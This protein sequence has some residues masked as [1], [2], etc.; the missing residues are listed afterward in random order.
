MSDTHEYV[1]Y[2]GFKNAKPYIKCDC[3]NCVA[4]G[5]LDCYVIPVPRVWTF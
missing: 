4:A 1:S 5:I 2:A 3:E